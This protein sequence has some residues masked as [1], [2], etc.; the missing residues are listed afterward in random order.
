MSSTDH[1]GH[2]FTT[3]DLLTDTT[4]YLR[5]PD[6]HHLRVR[7]AKQGDRIHVGD[8]A[9]RLVE[10]IIF[11]S[12]GAEVTA[13]VSEI[14]VIP[15]PAP[16]LTV[17]QGLA[18]S[19]KVDWVVEKLVELGVDE[20]VIFAAGRSVPVWGADK[21]KTVR[22]RW[23]RVAYAA[24]K[25]SRRAWLPVVTGPLDRK[26]LLERM[27]SMPAVLVADPQ[28][29]ASLGAALMD[30]GKV[31]EVGIVVGPEGGLSREEIAMLIDRGARPVSLGAQ[32][33][34]TETAGLALSAVVMHH[35]NRFG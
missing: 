14:T 20:I 4:V 32:I 12:T 11:T 9:G 33:L 1:H 8:G 23:E 21:A 30:L 10:A 27:K 24:S 2:F 29:G 6:A 3:P 18:K 19:D 26:E 13:T 5:G 15:P 28:A 31:A 7:R 25:Q 35:L 17:F 22:L 34:R 16:R